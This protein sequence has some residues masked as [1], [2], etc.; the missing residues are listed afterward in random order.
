MQGRMTMALNSQ[1]EICAVQKGG[2]IPVPVS[3]IL[4][5][6]RIAASKVHEIT[7]LIKKAL[8]E[9]NSARIKKPVPPASALSVQPVQN[10]IAFTAT[11]VFVDTDSMEV[12]AAAAAAAAAAATSIN[13]HQHD[14][15]PPP[16]PLA[17]PDS[18]S[19]DIIASETVH[20]AEEQALFQGAK[21]AWDNGEQPLAPATG[22][23]AAATT[24]AAT[25]A[26]K[27]TTKPS[28]ASAASKK[29]VA[30]KKPS[31][32]G[33]AVDLSVAIKPKA[34]KKP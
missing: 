28:T 17:G 29:P 33:G 24:K 14:T 30:K 2:G 27:T 31:T 16:S 26:T 12:S 19:M 32:G 10:T 21:S 23:G 34:K 1:Q 11:P 18:P 7:A 20:A 22:G 5:C 4:Q 9:H 3:A 6:S 15:L 25:K 8:E 13:Q